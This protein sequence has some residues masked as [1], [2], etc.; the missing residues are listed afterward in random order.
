MARKGYLK[1]DGDQSSKILCD[2]CRIARA[3]QQPVEHDSQK[4]GAKVDASVKNTVKPSLMQNIKQ[5]DL[6]PGDCILID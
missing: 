4:S 3:A 6:R 1:G 2:A 5:D